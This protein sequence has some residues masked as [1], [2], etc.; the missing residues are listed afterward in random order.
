MQY[1]K[2][3]TQEE[4][5]RWFQALDTDRNVYWIFSKD[6]ID[7]GLVH[8]KDIS[9]RVGEPGIFTGLESYLGTPI[10]AMAILVMM[11][12]GFDVLGLHELKA[13]IQVNNNINLWTNLKFGYEPQHI[14][15]GGGFE[16]YSVNRDSFRNHTKTLRPSLEKLY[17]R[18]TTFEGFTNADGLLGKAVNRYKKKAGADVLFA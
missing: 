3:I 8:I 16:Y 11:D 10:P 14:S 9:N 4:Q 1:S 15:V 5:A 17:G 12:I 2:L 6:E 13:K 18:Q 7:I